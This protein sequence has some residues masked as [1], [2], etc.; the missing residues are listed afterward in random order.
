MFKIKYLGKEQEFEKKVSL[1]SLLEPS[2]KYNYLA[3]KVNNRLRELTYEV[4]YDCEV[5]FLGF[6]NYNA[7]RVYETSLRYLVALAFE[8]LYPD[9]EIRFSYNVSRALFCQ[10]L[11]NKKTIDNELLVKLNHEMKDLIEKDLPF[12][13]KIVTN[14]EALQI[15]KQRGFE[16]KIDSLAYRPEKTVHFYECDGYLNYM[17]GYMVPSTGYLKQYVLR[18]HLPGIIIQ[19][20]RS[21]LNGN[22]GPFEYASTYGHTL[23]QSYLWAKLIDAETIAKVNQ[24]AENSKVEFVNICETK[25]NNMLAELGD[26]IKKDIENIRLIAIAGPSSSGK[27][28]FANRLRIELMSKGIRPVK[29]SIDDY[30]KVKSEC[31]RDENGE[32]DLEHIDAIDVELFNT[33]LLA[34]IQGEEVELPK[35][36]FQLQKRVPGK[37]IKV[38]SNSPIIIE[39]IHALNEK[40]TSLIPK[41]QKFKI[42]ISPQIQ[43]NLDN[44]NP[45]SL[46]DIRLLRRL[47]RDYKYR[48]SPAENTFSMWGSVRRGEFKWIYPNQETADY[49][50]NSELTYELCVLKK[51]AMPLLKAVSND[52]EHFVTANRL[53]KYIKYFKDIEDSLVPCNSILR[54][55]IGDSCFKDV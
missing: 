31:P 27:T 2:V 54:E 37:K 1:L 43:L 5:E 23:K 12:T 36:D 3:A 40:L 50:F 39:G 30:Y 28:T 29:I 22:I 55:F 44:H 18:L 21:E 13:R 53:I 15:Y 48:N 45:I 25:H 7:I 24:Q 32:I 38:D 51:Y 46:T 26:M 6:D 20:P 34:L 52:S 16:D 47:V 14:Q 41:Y 42:Y 10:I 35:F 19:Y 11:D 17:Y 49:V 4:N 8:R 9:L 33:H